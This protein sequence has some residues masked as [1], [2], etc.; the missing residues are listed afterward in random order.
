[1][2]AKLLEISDWID[3]EIEIGEKIKPT[4]ERAKTIYKITKHHNIIISL[5][6]FQP[7]LI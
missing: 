7:T 5:V 6:K 1:M 2:E 3:L 4:C